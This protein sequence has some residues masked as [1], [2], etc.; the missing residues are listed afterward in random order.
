MEEIGRRIAN[1]QTLA[2]DEPGRK[3]IGQ[4]IET[5]AQART[6]QEQLN[7][8]AIFALEK[9]FIASAQTTELQLKTHNLNTQ[10]AALQAEIAGLR[11]KGITHFLTK[12]TGDLEAA[13]AAMNPLAL[14]EQ[15]GDATAQLKTWGEELAQYPAKA[16]I[17]IQ[18]SIASMQKQLTESRQAGA[19]DVIP[20]EYADAVEAYKLAL[21][22]P[23]GSGTNYNELYQ[24]M[25][26]A[27]SKSQ[28]AFDATN[29]GIQVRT[30]DENVKSYLTE[31][32]SLLDSF[33]SVTDFSDR[34]LVA[35]S[36]NRN[37]DV[38]KELQYD[39]TATALRARSIILRDK[40]R[41]LDPPAPRKAVHDV[42]VSTFEEFVLMAGLFE[43]FGE[44]EKYDKSLRDVYVQEAYRKLDNVKQLTATV[45]TMLLQPE[46]KKGGVSLDFLKPSTWGK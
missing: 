32:N 25:S 15:Y 16:E 7:Y 10:R 17:R 18:E 12:E 11:Q 30:Y 21:S 2:V 33:S 4:L 14:A 19:L 27:E 29:L 9:G 8:Q 45:Q 40:A 26:A 34:M 23:K 22:Y 24:L 20:E 41:Q 31:M 36:T 46:G 37:V 5:A 38:Y 42:A 28:A 44:Y 1:L 13:L 3:M 43:R 6:A 39:L 35:S